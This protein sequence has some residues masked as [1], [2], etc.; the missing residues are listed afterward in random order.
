[1]RISDWS[2]DVCSS[3]LTFSFLQDGA[4]RS[5][6]AANELGLVVVLMPMMS[7]QPHAL[8]AA[9]KRIGALARTYPTLNIV[10]AHFG[11]PVAERTPTFGFSPAN[12]ALAPPRHVNHNHTTLLLQLLLT[13]S[14]P[15]TE[16]L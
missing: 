7:D 12:L 4:L 13:G 10:L 14:H 6:E 15:A 5:W 16:F 1:M 3:D 11:F 8:P 9:M 2:A